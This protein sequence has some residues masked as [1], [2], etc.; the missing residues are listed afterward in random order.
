MVNDRF[1]PARLVT[2]PDITRLWSLATE[3]RPP[4][5]VMYLSSTSSIGTLGM[6]GPRPPPWPACPPGPP[7]RALTAP[8]GRAATLLTSGW[9]ARGATGGLRRHRGHL[10]GREQL[11]QRR[12]SLRSSAPMAG[13][14]GDVHVALEELVVDGLHDLDHL[15]GGFLRPLLV[16][17]ERELASRLLD[18]AVDAAK[19][20]RGLHEMHRG[21]DLIGRGI[22]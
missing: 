7:G 2:V 6:P 17:V 18:V 5:A 4:I 11:R 9:A 14:A 16:L 22:L 3:A 1:S 10:F 21:L 13:R 12:L 15:A 20:G 8:A 19:A